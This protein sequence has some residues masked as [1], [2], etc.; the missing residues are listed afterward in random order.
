MPNNQITTKGQQM[1]DKIYSTPEAAI[2]LSRSYSGLKLYIKK[3][4]LIGTKQHNNL[5][6]FTQQELDDFAE[7]YPIK[8]ATP[9]TNQLIKELENSTVKILAQ[10]YQVSL[11]TIYRWM[12]Y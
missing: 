5:R 10:K 2:Y 6:W 4:H 3:G 12:T 8:L 7:K 11:K 9:G 1:T